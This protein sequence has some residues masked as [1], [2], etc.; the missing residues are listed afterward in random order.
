MILGLLVAV[1]QGKLK[2]WREL[3]VA[4]AA[5]A[6]VSLSK[7]STFQF[8]YVSKCFDASASLYISCSWQQLKLAAGNKLSEQAELQKFFGIALPRRQH[9][10]QLPDLAFRLCTKPGPTIEGSKCYHQLLT[11]TK[12][13]LWILQNSLKLCILFIFSIFS[14]TPRFL[15]N[16]PPAPNLL[17]LWDFYVFQLQ[18]TATA[19]ASATQN[20]TLA[21]PALPRPVHTGSIRSEAEKVWQTW[22]EMRWDSQRMSIFVKLLQIRQLCQAIKPFWPFG[23]FDFNLMGW[24]CASNLKHH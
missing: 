2:L 21:K 5:D 14:K 20:A 13:S 11:T 19:V 16:L 8:Q 17:A 4:N 3:F 1:H 9:Y 22:Y 10:P 6:N 15:P 24:C 23:G 18:G 7:V 12:H